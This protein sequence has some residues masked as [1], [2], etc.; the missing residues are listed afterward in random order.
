[1]TPTFEIMKP[2]AEP[3][4]DKQATK[5]GKEGGEQV[6]KKQKSKKQDPA[7]VIQQFIKNLN[8]T[9]E[10]KS[11]SEKGDKVTKKQSAESAA[12]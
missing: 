1:M 8:K 7:E 3:I 6:Q 12:D 4:K 5:V 11:H 2:V 9:D 10:P